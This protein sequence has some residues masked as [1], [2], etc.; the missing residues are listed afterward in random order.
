[1]NPLDGCITLSKSDF[2]SVDTQKKIKDILKGAK[3][4][5][6][7]SDMAPNACGLKDLDHDNI[8]DLCVSVLDFSYPVLKENGVL[9]CKL[10]QGS[11]QSYLESLLKRS[12]SSVKLVKPKASRDDSA[13]I[14]LLARN[15]IGQHL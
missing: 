1:M 6:V 10:W 12:F 13:E 3:A 11:R 4:D 8:I 5:A 9:L 7:V 2:T 15:F 14:Y